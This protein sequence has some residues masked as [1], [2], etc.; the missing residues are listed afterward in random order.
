MFEF[1]LE[2]LRPYK[3]ETLLFAVSFI[4]PLV[5]LISLRFQAF[6]SAVLSYSLFVMHRFESFETVSFYFT[7]FKGTQYS[8][9][10]H[11]VDLFLPVLLLAN[12]LNG[13]LKDKWNFFPP[14]IVIF[15]LATL[16]PA[17]SMIKVPSELLIRSWFSIWANIRMLLF[18][19]CVTNLLKIDRGQRVL[20]KTFGVLIIYTGLKVIQGRYIY[21][22]QNPNGDFMTYNQQGYIISGLMGVFFSI[23]LNDAR[24]MFN[25]NLL[26]TVLGFGGAILILSQNRGAQM[27]FF[28]TFSG[29]LLLDLSLRLNFSK[30]R[31]LII[32]IIFGI[33]AGIKSY[34]TLYQRYFGA[35]KNLE[36]TR[37]RQ[38]FYVR[39]WANFTTNPWVGIGTNQ[40]GAR[41]YADPAAQEA[42]IQSTWFRSP[43]KDEYKLNE[44][45][46]TFNLRQIELWKSRDPS[47]EFS[48]GIVESYW[49]LCLSEYGLVGFI[50]LV[51]MWLYFY[52]SA[53]RNSFYFRKKNVVLYSYSM[54]SFGAINGMLFHNVTEW[55]ARQSQAMYFIAVHFAIVS[56]CN[57]FRETKRYVSD[58]PFKDSP[59]EKMIKDKNVDMQPT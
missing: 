46:H 37:Q 55:C 20:L 19:F 58:S 27:N 32:I 59:E 24:K 18:F 8:M 16:L 54:G 53:I 39:A 56:L 14:G 48:G 52:F 35:S 30:I 47:V 15:I 34:D 44:I 51:M 7:Q 28:F 23:L 12:I 3:Y 5:L 4:L 22:Y 9:S 42:M 1:L 11:H 43:D 26:W 49:F 2:T 29:I 57:H 41:Q 33:L 17:F 31:T 50:P 38:S 25:R 40:F 10:I 6:Q 21:G 45:T 36:G 13:R